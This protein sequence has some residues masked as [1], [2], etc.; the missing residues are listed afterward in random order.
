MVRII[1]LI[2]NF[3]KVHFCESGRYFILFIKWYRK[4]KEF[5]DILGNHWSDFPY[6]GSRILLNN[7]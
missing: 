3:Y 4:T 5:L 1:Y 2:Q 6:Q 7:K